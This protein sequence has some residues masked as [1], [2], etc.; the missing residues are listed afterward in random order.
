MKTLE[1][2]LAKALKA[3]GIQ[4]LN[5]V[6]LIAEKK[7]LFSSR[8]SYALMSQSRTG[9]TFAGILFIANEMFKAIQKGKK[10]DKGI[11]NELAIFIA[12]FHASARETAATISRYFG[13]FLRPLVLFRGV[14][15]SDIIVRLSKGLPPNIIIATPDALCEFLRY[16]TTRSWLLNQTL[17]ASVLDDAHSILHDPMRGL[18]LFEV[19]SILS[20]ISNSN[21]RMLVLSA[22]FEEPERL[23]SYFGVK[24]I[25]DESK[26]LPP[27]IDLVKYNKTKE[28]EEALNSLLEDLADE[29][30]RTLVYMKSIDSIVSYIDSEGPSLADA[31][32]YD[33]D[34]LIKERL[35]SISSI[36]AEVGYPSP[37]TFRG[38]IG[39]YHGLLSESQRWFVEWAFR[40]GYLRFLFGTE[41]L[42]YGVTAPVS[43]VVM[44]SPGI[45][46]I[47]RQSMMAR[48]VRLRRGKIRPGNCTVFTKSIEDV[49][50]LKKV[51]NSPTM[52]VRFIDETNV[53]SLLIGLIGHGII[54]TDDDRRKVSENLDLFFKKGSTSKTLKT[55]MSHEP[56]FIQEAGKSELSLT[57]LGRAAF[58]SSIAFP[59]A[60]RILEGLALLESTKSVPTMM[61]LLLLVNY[62]SSLLGRKDKTSSDLSDTA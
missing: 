16:D 18:R 1:P 6:Q 14:E 51:Y 39:I 28:K 9:K 42:G 17:V 12:P 57:S 48:A 40:R 19:S 2:S 33:L 27:E 30:T 7:G 24:L 15:E 8:D 34:P 37:V 54:K 25:Q 44:E 59:V 38:G 56:P 45:D 43:H 35:N 3:L 52:P 61:D 55:M 58:V 36:I 26:Y 50:A 32:S 5:D 10:S 60:A 31:V 62:S 23:E 47:F 53:S 49:G 11:C 13:W 4:E 22:E 20:T 46:E 29:G 21:S 41:A